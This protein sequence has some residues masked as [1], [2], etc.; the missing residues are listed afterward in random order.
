MKKFTA[1]LVFL[2]L[3]LIAAGCA[4]PKDTGN[5]GSQEDK[6]FQVTVEDHL[7]RQ[8]RLSQKPQ[9]IISLAPSNT[10]MLFALG[11][12]ER[13]V[14]VT[15]YCNYPIE[16]LQKPKAGSFAE[17]NIEKVV[18][19]QPDL[20]VAVRMQEEELARLEDLGIP[21][22]V[23]NPT[24]IEEVYRS[25]E[26]LGLAAGEEES[27]RLLVA[28]I[29]GKIDAVREKLLEVPEDKRVRVYYEVY[30]DPLMSVGCT[31]VIHELIEAAGG[32]N[33][34]ADVEAPYPK[35]S[36]EAVIDRDP[37]VIVFPN[38]HGTEEVLAN[39]IKSRP[40]W[41]AITAITNERLFGID[42]DKIS[43][44]GPRIADAVEE[45]AMIFYPEL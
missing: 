40:G 45:M 35:V 9:R 21:V 8:V 11:L 7:G 19:L 2:L 22:L 27:A 15:E 18:A 32:V 17:P 3:L 10:E 29:R 14:G 12:A 28:G 44:P 42:P 13:I 34:F 20:V 38:Y 1:S 41:G 31:S 5:K 43:R 33:I 39:E 37:Q 6:P 25:I 26:L 24:C 23:L 16:A 30:A 4:Q 36:A